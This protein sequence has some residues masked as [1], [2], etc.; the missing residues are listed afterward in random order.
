VDKIYFIFSINNLN[1]IPRLRQQ[2]VSCPQTVYSLWIKNA[3]VLL[4]SFPR[5]RAHFTHKLSGECA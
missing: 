2:G 5:G 3:G 1:K 4:D